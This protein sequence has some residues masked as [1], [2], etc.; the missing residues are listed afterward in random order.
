MN[1]QSRREPELRSAVPVPDPIVFV[2]GTG[3]SGTHVVARLLGRHST[4]HNITNEVRFHVDPGGF[5]DLLEGRTTPEQFIGRLRGRWWRGVALQRLSLRG[6]H[7]IIDRAVFDLAC[8]RFMERYGDVPELACRELFLELLGPLA[9]AEGKSGLIEQSCDTIAQ[10][11]TLV[12]L[13]PEARFIHVVRDGRDTAA[14]RVAQARWLARPRTIK[15]GLEWWEGRLRRIDAAKRQI[16]SEQFIA[17]SLDEL[18]EMRRLATYSRLRQFL[19]LAREQWMRG[20][21]ERKISGGQGNVERWRR[22]MSPSRQAEVDAI[23]LEILGRLDDDQINGCRMLKRVYDRRREVA[24][25]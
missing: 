14:S 21:F 13:F 22:R 8:D 5:P 23:Y 1:V 16:P 19:G 17:F 20:F 6:L 3:R 11:P 12:R 10:G 2:G 25:E 9:A 7:R 24:A 18:I 15:Q 4:L